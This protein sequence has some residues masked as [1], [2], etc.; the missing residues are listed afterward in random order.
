[1]KECFKKVPTR[2][3]SHYYSYKKAMKCLLYVYCEGG[4]EGGGGGGGGGVV[5]VVST[6]SI[7]GGLNGLVS[8]YR[9]IR[10]ILDSMHVWRAIFRQVMPFSASDFDGPVHAKSTPSTLSWLCRRG[11]VNFRFVPQSSTHTILTIKQYVLIFG[12]SLLC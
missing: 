9:P 11:T 7:G 10:E 5:V 3:H 12:S 1:M 6:P 8:I 4:R 2:L